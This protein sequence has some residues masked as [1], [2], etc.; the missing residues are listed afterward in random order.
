MPIAHCQ[1]PKFP[2]KE[3]KRVGT[4]MLSSSLLLQG[5]LPLKKLFSPSNDVIPNCHLVYLELTVVQINLLFN[6]GSK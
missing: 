5:Y 1:P 2:V 3:G 6:W 4:S